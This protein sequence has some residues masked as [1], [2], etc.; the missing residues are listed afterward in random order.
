MPMLFKTSFPILTLCVIRNTPGATTLGK[1]TTFFY[2]IIVN[3]VAA[4]ICWLMHNLFDFVA[5]DTEV[6]QASKEELK[7]TKVLSGT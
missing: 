7:R 4:Q 3:A 2:N 5:S 6:E 1:N